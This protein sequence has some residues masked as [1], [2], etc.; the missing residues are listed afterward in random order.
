MEIEGRFWSCRRPGLSF[1]QAGRAR[2]GTAPGRHTA[3]PAARGRSACRRRSG[4]DTGPGHSDASPGCLPRRPKPAG[5]PERTAGGDA[6]DAHARV[7]PLPAPC[8][9]GL[10][11]RRAWRD[12]QHLTHD[13]LRV[14][15][16]MHRLRPVHD[17]DGPN[18]PCRT[19]VARYPCRA[20][21][22]SV[23]AP[24]QCRA[25]A[26]AAPA[27]GPWST[28]A[29][30]VP[31][32]SRAAPVQCACRT[33]ARITGRARSS[34][35]VAPVAGGTGLAAP[36]R[37]SLERIVWRSGPATPHRVRSRNGP[38]RFR[39]SRATHRPARSRSRP[40]P[41][42]PSAAPA[43]RGARAVLR[44][45]RRRSWGCADAPSH[46]AGWHPLTGRA[47]LTAPA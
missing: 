31:R 7:M 12:S 23:S 40:C 33:S 24:A 9:A 17:R 8:S 3:P 30:S 13:R 10:H 21:T 35:R 5:W 37:R 26:H 28:R 39:V 19:S 29:V 11:L 6:C 1:D 20:H 36:A 46:R 45:V 25:C 4:W 32:P 47:G 42:A 43:P 16:R 44:R 2:S 14:A 22:R 18:P 15:Q 41:P 27:S 34:C 38:C